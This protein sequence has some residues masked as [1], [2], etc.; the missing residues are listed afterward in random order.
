[1]SRFVN[2][3]GVL[4][5][6]LWAN[7]VGAATGSPP[8]PNFN[9]DAACKELMKVPEALSVD[10]GMPTAI[11]HCVDA[12]QDA[13]NQLTREWT[14]FSPADRNLCVGESKSGSVAPAY[15]E[16]ESCLQM[17]RDTRQRNNQQTGENNGQSTKAALRES[18]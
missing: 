18:R 10:T 4:A 15:S 3:A 1:V 9:V 2:V 8:I 13:R 6:G 17:A 11:R 16:L 7:A 14:Q 12:E 5:I